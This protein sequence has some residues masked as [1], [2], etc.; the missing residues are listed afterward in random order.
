MLTAYE[1]MEV[2]ELVYF[3]FDFGVRIKRLYDFTTVTNDITNKL[4]YY[5]R[6][7]NQDFEALIDFKDI[8]EYLIDTSITSTSNSFENIKGI[9][10]LILREIYCN[11]TIYEPNSSYNYPQ[12]TTSA[13]GSTIDNRLRPI[14]LGYKQFPMLASGMI[15]YTQET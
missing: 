6:Q 3:T 9:R 2:P 8:I 12:Y 1:I 4:A 11:E 13:Y 7:A 10:N 15:T 14:Q 5:F